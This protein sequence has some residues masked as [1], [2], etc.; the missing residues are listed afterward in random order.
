MSL[1]SASREPDERFKHSPS[2]SASSAPRKRKN[3]K[4]PSE[5]SKFHIV[6]NIANKA[7]VEMLNEISGLYFKRSEQQKGSKSFDCY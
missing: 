3:K 2:T 5:E 1:R 7:I 6:K 4:K